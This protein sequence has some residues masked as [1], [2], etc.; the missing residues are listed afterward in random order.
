V[1][2]IAVSLADPA[3]VVVARSLKPETRVGLPAS[4][5]VIVAST[6]GGHGVYRVAALGDRAGEEGA[7]WLRAA[8]TKVPPG[9]GN[10]LLVTHAPNVMAAFAADGQGMEDGEALVIKPD[11]S[12]GFAV[13]GRLRIEEWP[14]LAG[15]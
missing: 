3:G 8:A 15:T 13:V 10:A 11:G 9:A 4:E 1:D 6:R 14:A 2:A 5:S 7:A 12:G